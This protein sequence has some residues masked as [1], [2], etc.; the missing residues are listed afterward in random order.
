MKNIFLNL[1]ISFTIVFSSLICTSG[2]SQL[3]FSTS[4]NVYDVISEYR[5]KLDTSILNAEGGIGKEIRNLEMIWGQRL[6]PHGD[7]TIAAQAISNYS[8][9]YALNQ[10]PSTQTPKWRCVGPTGTDTV[11]DKGIGHLHRI[12]F[13]PNYDDDACKT[14]YAS[15]SF[16]GLWRTHNNGDSWHVVN[17]DLLPFAGVADVC[18]NP[19]DTAQ[20]FISTG[21]ADGGTPYYWGP[22]WGTINTIFTHG[23]FRSDD[24]GNTWQAINT[25]FMDDFEQGGASRRMIINPNNPD[26]IFIATSKGIY[27]TE[28]ATATQPEN[29]LW[30]NVFNGLPG[31]PDVEFRGLAFHPLYDTV[32]YASGKDIYKSIDGGDT[33]QSMTGAGVGLNLND[34]PYTD[35][36]VLN[37]INIA[38]TNASGGHDHVY[39]IIEG[40]EGETEPE[41]TVYIYVFNGTQW[42]FAD[43]HPYDFPSYSSTQWI[44]I[45]ASPLDYKKVYYGIS[46][47]Y[48]T[49]DYTQLT[50]TD[51]PRF[52]ELSYYTVSG[53]F[54]ADIHDIKFQPVSINNQPD[55]Y[56]ATHG[57]MNK[58]GFPQSG[59]GNWQSKNGGLQNSL[60]WAFDDAENDT[61]N[62][63]VATQCNGIVGR[64]RNYWNN[65]WGSFQG[66]CD[67][68]TGRICDAKP[69]LVSFSQSDEIFNMGYFEAGPVLNYSKPYPKDLYNSEK[70]P[71][72]ST[73]FP[74]VNNPMT[75]SL[76]FGFTELYRRKKIP[77]HSNE[78]WTDVWGGASDLYKKETARWKRQITELVIC[79]SDTNTM[80]LVTG[81]VYRNDSIYVSSRLFK[82]TTGVCE[83][84][85]I[86]T[87]FVELTQPYFSGGLQ[88]IL[89]GITVDPLNE[90]RVWICYSGYYD[91]Y[92]VWHS[93]DGGL[94]WENYDPLG[95]LHNLPV[96][97]I[98][99]QYGSTDRIYIGTDAGVYTRDANNTE[100]E[101][102]GDFPNVRVTEMK[103]NYC[104]GKLMVATFGRGVWEGDLIEYA[105]PY[106][107]IIENNIELRR[108]LALQGSLLITNGAEV[109]V[110]E[111]I[112]VPKGH[113]IVIEPGSKLILDGGIITNTCGDLWQGIEVWGDPLVYQ[114]TPLYHGLLHIKNGGR[115]E[116]AVIGVRAGSSNMPGKGGGIIVATDAEFANNET[117]VVYDPYVFTNSGYFRNC[118]FDYSHTV[119]GE[120]DLTFVRLNNVK[121]VKFEG[122]NFTN[123]SNQDHLG[124]GIE[125]FNSIF[126]VLEECTNY[127][128]NECTDWDN[129]SF[130]N[131]NYGVYATA[132]NATDFADIRHTNFNGNYRG[133]Y[134]SGMTLPRVTSNKIVLNDVATNESYGLYLDG[135][136]QYWV[137][138]NTFEGEGLATE[139][140]IGIVVNESG[141]DA[142]LIYLNT[143]NYVEYAINVQG[144]NR[145]GRLNTK[146]LEIRCN[147]F[148]NTLFDIS[149]IFDGMFIPQS[150]GVAS[151]QGRNT[152]LAEDMA[153]NLFYYNTSVSGD[154]DDINNQSNHFYYY[155][156][157]NAGIYHVEPLDYTASTVTIVPKPILD[158]TYEEGCPS[159]LTTGGGGGTEGLRS[160]LFEAQSGIE[161]TEAILA[162]LIDGGNTEMLNTEVE[163]STPPETSEIYT[164][165]MTESPNL[166]E[167]VVETSIVKE[168]VLPNAMIR[169]IMVA[170]PHTS[171]SLQL[172]DK[173]DDRANP[174]PA[175]MKAQILA[176]RSIQSLKTELE[177][178]LASYHTNKY[179]AMSSLAR[180][181]GQMP[182]NPAL[183][184]S[185]IALYQSDNSID[186]RYMQAWLNL[187]NGQYV[188]GQNVM[189]GI[190]AA[191]TLSVD[192]L[193]E[194]QNMQWLYTMLKGL[195]ESG[196]GLDG[197]SEVQIVQLHTI[198]TDE[199]TFASVYA[200][201]IL[202]AIDELEYL[203]PVLLPNSTKSTNAEEAYNEVLNSQAP[204][205]LEVYPNPSK[206]FVIIG[207]QFDKETRGMIVIRDITGK[208]VQSISF[209]GMQDQVTVTTRGWITGV[210]I[211]N[212]VVNGNVIETTKFTLIK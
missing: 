29:V 202:L 204:S 158:W 82:T 59:T 173:L 170:N 185:L 91:N 67:G 133:V 134:L 105:E 48:G 184:D 24:Y 12:N 37:R 95:L 176:G 115:I 187:Q 129:G 83:Y 109:I 164:F 128:G 21:Y 212:L 197:I 135:C 50:G 90:N 110:K 172:L 141:S 210:Y 163:T 62:L 88:P 89:T 191:F 175:Y 144:L 161:S 72:F 27:R 137:E 39:A 157:N 32:V 145:D 18:V 44:A 45:A 77:S 103:I 86:D 208:P 43:K 41:S 136:T 78:P 181:F 111:M 34:L 112:N 52:N 31:M 42:V 2:V 120:I 30:T 169:D 156:S 211:L 100:W 92:K 73:T 61:I 106:V 125:S 160:S 201:N 166:S 155:Y 25:G 131:L 85:S 117:C 199:T 64:M 49:D 46:V 84:P 75:N 22:N 3:D 154:F 188:Q 113:R 127:S 143:F 97:A 33:W 195:F 205:M 58:K 107:K 96:N 51:F 193:A 15:S 63:I 69:G 23:N 116:N 94:S 71:L 16:A 60:V 118:T 186:S 14:I 66:F 130:T 183:T 104:K 74:M 10:L 177:G 168:E 7:G 79:E 192:E 13:A 126:R 174:L 56:C 101:K 17:T 152:T 28:N 38:T 139:K 114:H 99:Y 4:S 81:G 55:L 196:N 1:K 146:G 98:V 5:S 19:N 138:D 53:G 167:T 198:V 68:Y 140:G 70:P 150:H 207:Y 36:F 200:R 47:L 54:H 8:I 124:I 26:Q 206:D 20:I 40:N 162:A 102:Y 147:N 6:F 148:D 122:S 159:N 76:F 57:G 190:L 203:E 119:S 65:G 180:Y 171:T 151:Q 142:N 11:I 132:A 165:L 35:F 178:Q 179:R 149:V 121:Y 87:C 123:N 209:N 80:Y 189:A 153:G 194:Y 93:D 9:N 108:N 182:E